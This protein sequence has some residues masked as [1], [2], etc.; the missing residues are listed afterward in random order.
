MSSAEVSIEESATSSN[1]RLY[2]QIALKSASG[3]P[4]GGVEVKVTLVGDGSLAPQFDSKEVFRIT[5]ED[6][7]ANVT[8]YRRNI[9]GRGVRATLTVSAPEEGQS[10]AL[11]A[12][13]DAPAEMVG[14]RTEW[15]PQRRRW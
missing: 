6:G 3:E 8:W 7:T 9:W 5:E 15:T 11:E 2:W 14:P 12:M 1:A 13:S 4:M 10:M